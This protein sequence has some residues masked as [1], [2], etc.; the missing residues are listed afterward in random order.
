MSDR[1]FNRDRNRPYDNDFDDDFFDRDFDMNDRDW[2]SSMRGGR[3]DYGRQ[4]YGRGNYGA[5][6]RGQGRGMSRGMNRGYGSQQGYGQQG[7]GQQGYGQ[8]GYGSEFS[9]GYGS[10]RRGGGDFGSYG[11]GGY[12]SGRGF[13]RQDYGYGQQQGSFFEDEYEMDFDDEPMWIYEEE[14]WLIPGPFSGIGPE[15]YHRSDERIKEDIND[16]LTQ[17]GQIDARKVH[18]EV[19]NGEA[20]LTGEVNHRE[21]KRMCED[22]VE[23]VSG[24]RDVH[25]Q[26]RVKDRHQQGQH[27]G[28]QGQHQGQ[29]GQHQGQQGQMTGQQGQMTGQQGRR[30]RQDQ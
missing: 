29:Q 1:Y 27:Q 26:L 13:G 17:H 12:G 10:R 28:Q 18:V 21:V 14:I 19:Q 7:Y 6:G 4:D 30:T 15:D 24:V 22:V 16:R 11:R 8:Q 3:Q 25:N 9:G 5:G 23:S 2:R 20:T